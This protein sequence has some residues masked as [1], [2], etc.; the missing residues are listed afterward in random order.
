MLFIDGTK[1][2]TK[3]STSDGKTEWESSLN[4]QDGFLQ[5]NGMAIQMLMQVNISPG[6]GI[7]IAFQGDLDTGGT[8]G[9][10]SLE[11]THSQLPNDTNIRVYSCLG[12]ERTQTDN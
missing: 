5:F 4:R 3:F 10:L 6:I 11:L 7:Y 12:Y 1:L 2:R 9:V 8:E